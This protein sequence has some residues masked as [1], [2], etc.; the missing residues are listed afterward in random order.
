MII[1]V[2]CVFR[3]SVNASDSLG[4]ESRAG[5]ARVGAEPPESISRAPSRSA[6]LRQEPPP[7]PLAVTTWT[8]DRLRNESD[9]DAGGTRVR[10]DGRALRRERPPGSRP[11]RGNDS[12]HH[13]SR[14]GRRLANGIKRSRMIGELRNCYI[15]KVCL[16][17]VG[18]DYQAALPGGMSQLSRLAAGRATR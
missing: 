17:F 4:S 13:G 18:A 16:F 6:P 10:V 5:A 12:N 11:G 8:S 9:S 14:P 3:W 2:G 15:G 1:Q 7:C